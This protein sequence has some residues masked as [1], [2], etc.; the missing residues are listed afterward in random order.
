MERVFAVEPTEKV[1]FN[2]HAI[3]L[4]DID[5]LIE[6]GMYKNRDEF[7]SKAIERQLTKNER[8]IE[9]L[10]ERY[11]YYLGIVT[12]GKKDLEKALRDNMKLELK[13]IGMLNLK[14]DITPDLATR[15]IK[16]IKVLG[17]FKS[18]DILKEVLRDKI[19]EG[20]GVAK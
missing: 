11:G 14:D 17:I 3:D 10:T 5:L 18:D 1:T 6:S 19:M 4:G 7:L 12:Y 8:K 15:T 9:L 13:I 20:A 2:V 16:S